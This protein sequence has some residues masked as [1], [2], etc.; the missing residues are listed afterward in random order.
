MTLSLDL[1][2][3]QALELFPLIFAYNY[4]TTEIA[5]AVREGDSGSILSLQPPQQALRQELERRGVMGTF[6]KLKGLEMKKLLEQAD[7]AE[8]EADERNLN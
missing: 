3:P 7:E 1:D 6:L 8:G 4:L 2:H 5:R